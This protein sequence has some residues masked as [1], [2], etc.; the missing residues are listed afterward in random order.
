MATITP[1]AIS[2]VV[3]ASPI[4]RPFVVFVNCLLCLSASPV[5]S[6]F[7]S[8]APFTSSIVWRSWSASA[9]RT[10]R[11]SAIS[12]SEPECSGLF[13]RPDAI[14]VCVQQRPMSVLYHRAPKPDAASTLKPC[15]ST[16]DDIRKARANREPREVSQAHRPEGCP[17]PR[18]VSVIH[19]A[20]ICEQIHLHL[21]RLSVVSERVAAEEVQSNIHTHQ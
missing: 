11:I 12:A 21:W 6:A 2:A 19:H 5:A 9:V 14:S 1:L 20:P 16:A 13:T 3:A 15:P 4:A 7:S 8:K 18:A 17:T 10:W